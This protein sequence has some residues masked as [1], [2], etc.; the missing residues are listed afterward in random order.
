MRPGTRRWRA[1]FSAA[2]GETGHALLRPPRKASIAQASVL[3]IDGGA[4]A[5]YLLAVNDSFVNTQADWQQVT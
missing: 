5:K 3:Q 1:H 2:L 4:D